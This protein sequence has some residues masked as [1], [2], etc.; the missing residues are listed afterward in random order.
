MNN[1]GNLHNFADRT[2]IVTGAASGIGKEIAFQ[3][4]A[5]GPRVVVAD[6]AE[7]RVQIAQMICEGGGEAIAIDVDVSN[8]QSVEAMTALTEERFGRID[9]LVHC[10]GVGI[11]KPFLETTLEEW[12]R[13]INIDLTGTFLC[14]QA[15]AKV[16]VKN[17]YG[18]IIN[19]ASTAALRGGFHRAAY[20]AAKGGVVTLTKVMAVEL[21]AQGIT[22]NA[23]APGAIETELVAQMHS[24]ETRKIYT[25][26][27]PAARYGTP[28]ET[29]AAALFLASDQASY[30]NG[31][32]MAV[33]GGFLGA[34][35]M[36]ANQ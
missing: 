28:A 34:G 5:C 8:Q 33:D 23:L 13:I 20:G 1:V 29:A 26:A 16:M 14:C 19:L 4:A 10:A 15:A 7:Q 9:I 32:V 2:A 6:R 35:L 31:H 30:V 22:V 27:I 17:Q 25:N 24:E 36:K 12:N 11:E 3:L 21:A 18:R